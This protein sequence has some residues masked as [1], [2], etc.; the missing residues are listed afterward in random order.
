MFNFDDFNLVGKDLF[1]QGLVDPVSGS[2]S[3]R[4]GDRIYITKRNAMLAHLKPEDIIEV[5]LEAPDLNDELAAW[6]VLVHRAVY[7]E[8]AFN[9]MVHAY[10][11][12]GIALSIGTENKILPIDG[13]GQAA[14]RSIPVVRAKPVIPGREKTTSDDIIKYLPPVFKSGYSAAVVKEYASFAVGTTLIEAFRNTICL[15]DSC[16]I[17]AIGKS[18]SGSGSSSSSDKHR[19]PETPVRRTALPPSIGVMG[20]SRG[21]RR[22]SSFGR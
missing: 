22:G 16:R 14:L 12:Y 13:K 5:P 17:V 1:A 11:P 8:T 10:P 3:V 20:N 4:E 15:E 9:A 19:R 6:E 21:G 7:K 18:L 2:L